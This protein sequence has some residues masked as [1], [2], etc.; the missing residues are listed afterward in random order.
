LTFKEID[1]TGQELYVLWQH[2]MAERG[3]GTDGWDDLEQLD[4]EV[5]CAL[6][7][8]LLYREDID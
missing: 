6:A 8:Q 7:T 5:W 4:R 3:V 1:M 2:K